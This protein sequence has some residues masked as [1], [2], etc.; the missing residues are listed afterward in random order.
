MNI[1]DHTLETLPD[2]VQEYVELTVLPAQNWSINANKH[3]GTISEVLG[4]Q[5]SVYKA[6]HINTNQYVVLRRIHDFEQ[7]S[8]NSKPILNIIEAW[9]KI[10]CA[11]IVRLLQVFQ[12]KAFGDSSLVIVY[13]YFSPTVTLMQQYFSDMSGGSIAGGQPSMYG[14]GAVNRPY[15][16]QS[17]LL[18]NKMI[19]ENLLWHYIIQISAALRIIHTQCGLAYR[20]ISPTKIIITTN[21]PKC[22]P[23]QLTPSQYPRIRLNACGLLDIVSQ[24]IL[25]EPNVKLFY[26]QQQQ[27]DLVEFGRLCLALATNSLS[28]MRQEQLDQAIDTV[29]RLYSNDLKALIV[30]LL[31]IKQN[32]SP[33][34]INDIMPMIGARFYVQ[35]NLSYEALDA[36]QA[37]L[38]RE[39]INGRLF[40]MISK[41]NM[42]IERPELRFDPSWSETGD[43]YML[44]LFR[45]YLFHQS[46]ED[47]TPWLDTGHVV[48]TLCKFDVGSLERI[49]LISRDEQ[50]ILVVSYEE[51]KK[52]FDK[53][54][55]ELVGVC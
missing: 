3:G 55:N 22:P 42:I 49:C 51:L 54:F 24:G 39:V 53:S 8:T 32:P 14:L 7:H 28:C 6:T 1:R 17:A 29:S 41:L 48:S 16:Q 38:D 2:R 36:R 31:S 27:N 23:G 21:L 43:R 30:T 4:Y 11:N 25:E 37:E 33:Q 9:K 12:T 13:Q 44:K 40:R 10:Q 52:C 15:S 5:S 19:P 47:G 35:L 46:N 18:K 50:H 45:D 20:M 34:T 26:L